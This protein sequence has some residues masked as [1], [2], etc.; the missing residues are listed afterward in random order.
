MLPPSSVRAGRVAVLSTA[1]ALLVSSFWP[2]ALP[3][4]VIINEIH[5]SPKDKTVREEFVEVYNDDQNVVD[6]SGWYFSQGID[7]T[8]P[9]GTSLAPGAYLV[10][11]EDPAVLKAL[12]PDLSAVVGPFSGG[13]AARGDH[14]VLRS[15]MGILMDEVDYRLGFP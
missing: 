7:F 3:A 6:L 15:A 11:A 1:V 14:L 9:A 12:Y 2:P 13:L 5:Y 8:F 10:V 4:G